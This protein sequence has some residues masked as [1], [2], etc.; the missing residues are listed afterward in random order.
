MKNLYNKVSGFIGKYIANLN[1]KL[2][3]W[4][5]IILAI[6]LFF[7]YQSN[8]INNLENKLEFE[9]KLKSALVDTMKIYKDKNSNLIYEKKTIQAELSIL[10]ET[11]IVL[12]DSQRELLNEV[13]ELN[14]KNT[15]IAAALID[16]QVQ[17]GQLTGFVGKIDTTK[18]QIHFVDSIPDFSFDL[19]VNNVLPYKSNKVTLDFNSMNFPNKQLIEFHWIDEAKKEGYP[20]SFSVK[21]TNK[22][23]VVNNIESYSIPGLDKEVVDPTTWMKIK[24]FCNKNSKIGGIGIGI[25]IA[26]GYFLFK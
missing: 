20:I 19:M 14:K 5:L 4:I 1:K 7:K 12:S 10:K 17:V 13:K 11:N 23:F 8:K 9:S 15:T 25:G 26:G 24:N 21:N 22:F 18:K 6:L 3:I 2:V 16:L